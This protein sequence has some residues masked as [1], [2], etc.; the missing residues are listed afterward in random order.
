MALIQS[1]VSAD[2]LTVDPTSKAARVALYGPDGEPLLY[3]SN[4]NRGIA[5]IRVRQ[6]AATA[7]G[8]VVWAIRNSS[9][10]KTL[11]ITKLWLQMWFD[12]T[13][14]ATEMKY[15][16]IKGTGCTAMSGGTAITPLLKR[17]TLTNPDVDCRV[18]DT[19]LTLTGV[20]QEPDPFW[21]AAMARLTHS[22]TQAGGIGTQHV[23]DISEEAPIELA[24]QET[25]SLRQWATS[26]LGDNIAGGCE[27]Y[28]G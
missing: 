3:I 17:T 13:G 23:L 5:H 4:R 10:G 24:Y 27:F 22:A 8:A 18:L 15:E 7:L 16:L 6:S 21:S 28:G 25:L 11:Y 1:G 20:T 9:A 26:V 2:L 14:A 19:G 12:G